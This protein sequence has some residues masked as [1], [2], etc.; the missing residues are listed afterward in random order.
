MSK[1]T[2]KWDKDFTKRYSDAIVELQSL[3]KEYKQMKIDNPDAWI[4]IYPE[5]TTVSFGECYSFY[6]VRYPENPKSETPHEHVDITLQSELGIFSFELSSFSDIKKLRDQLIEACDSFN[7]PTENK[8]LIEDDCEDE[9]GWE[10]NE[11]QEY[12]IQASRTCTETWTHTVMARS[13]CEAY[14]LVQ[15]DCDGST[16]D[17]NND[18]N[19]Y[20]EI[21]YEII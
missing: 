15:E 10:D 2:K 3:E 12:T 16:H 19:D 8:T 5:N 7:R 9:E 20:S 1:Y 17:E 14:R 11:E 21:D 18:Y 4:S 6:A 13:A